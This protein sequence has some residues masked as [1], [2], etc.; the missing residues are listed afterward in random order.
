[1]KKMKFIYWNNI[2]KLVTFIYEVSTPIQRATLLSICS[3]GS[4]W[5]SNDWHG[6][7]TK[8]GSMQLERKDLVET[9]PA[10]EQEMLA[11]G[12]HHVSMT[13]VIGGIL[14]G[15]VLVSAAVILI[16]VIILPFRGNLTP[17][18]IATFP[19]TLGELWIGLLGLHS[20]AIIT[21]GLLLLILT[22]VLRVAVSVIAFGLEHDRKYVIITLI[23]LAILIT[24]FILG[25]AGA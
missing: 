12:K 24:S 16:G 7:P 5:Q 20:Q 18:R 14:Q 8:D 19:H 11:F 13:T 17:Q 21:L 4:I 2:R 25:K 3:K 15:G 1:M 6:I 22:P 23:V 10:L 9:K